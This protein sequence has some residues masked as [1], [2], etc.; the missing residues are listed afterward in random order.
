[1]E[2]LDDEWVEEL[3]Q[4][5]KEHIAF[6]PLQMRLMDIEEEF[7]AVLKDLE[8]EQQDIIKEYIRINQKLEVWLTNQAYL[9]GVQVEKRAKK[10]QET[11]HGA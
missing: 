1:M 10:K 3:R 8:P 9:I 11:D 2:R 5:K 4:I 6:F 7:Y